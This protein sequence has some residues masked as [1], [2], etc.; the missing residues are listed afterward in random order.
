MKLTVPRN[1]CGYPTVQIHHS[2]PKNPVK[3]NARLDTRKLP[4]RPP[5]NTRTVALIGER[6]P[7][8]LAIMALDVQTPQSR[9]LM[10]DGWLNPSLKKVYLTNPL[11]HPLAR[12]RCI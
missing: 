11:P 3:Q 12:P 7:T 9:V 10:G 4:T 6:R 8:R 5:E 2:W 1:H